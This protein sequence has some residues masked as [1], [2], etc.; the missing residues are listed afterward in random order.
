MILG[1]LGTYKQWWLC[2]NKYEYPIYQTNL[3]GATHS[4]V[5]PSD[6]TVWRHTWQKKWVNCAVF[7]GNSAGLRTV[8]SNRLSNRELRSSFRE[9]HS[10]LSLPADTT[11]ASSKGTSVSSN[12]FSGW[13]PHDIFLF[14]YHFLLLSLRFL[15]V[16]SDNNMA[17]VASK[18]QT[19][20]FVFIHHSHRQK[21]K[22]RTDKNWQTWWETCAV[23]ENRQF[24]F[25]CS[26]LHKLHCLT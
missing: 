9:S 4:Q 18:Q 16:F 24:S 7:T 14:R 1:I 25:T 2:N 3:K 8:L 10:F 19:T 23:P 5:K 15:F 26:F 12:S 20:A 21:K 17:D 6:F 13:A 11:I 22:Y